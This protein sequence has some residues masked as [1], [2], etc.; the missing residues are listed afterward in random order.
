[1]SLRG[2]PIHHGLGVA[3]IVLAS[4]GAMS[5]WSHSGKPRQERLMSKTI[6]PRHALLSGA[7]CAITFG[8]ACAP[9]AAEA[10][11][12]RRQTFVDSAPDQ[13]ASADATADTKEADAAAD[14]PT[15]P[16]EETQMKIRL[17]I[18]AQ[19]LDATLDDNAASRDL[20]AQL[21]LILTL[22]DHAETEKVSDLPAALSTAGAPAGA[23]PEVGDIA[24][25]APWGNLAIYYRDFG[26]SKGLIKL[27][28]VEGDIARL[29]AH[30]GSFTM[31]IE[32]A[33]LKP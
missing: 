7:L 30:Q 31:R 15:P 1:M 27:G 28:R 25:Y 26:Y 16:A 6:H 14:L 8:C 22:R 17:V 10:D 9:D 4:R 11:P 2:C 5:G 23:D 19:V 3:Y 24:Y 21:P 13:E 32:R 33:D 20:I 12:A 29:A 18:G